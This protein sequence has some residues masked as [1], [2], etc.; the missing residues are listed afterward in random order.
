MTLDQ[1]V[2]RI[3]SSHGIY[4]LL[5]AANLLMGAVILEQGHV[6]ENQRVL[7]KAMFY[8]DIHSAAMRLRHVVDRH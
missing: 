3:K 6:I 8:D 4:V 7:I 2:P 1:P 5:L